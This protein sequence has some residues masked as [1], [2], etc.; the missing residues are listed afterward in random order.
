[1]IDIDQRNT[2][3]IRSTVSAQASGDTWG[4]GEEWGGGATWGSATVSSPT[5][6]SGTEAY[7]H[8]IRYEHSGVDTPVEIL[9]YML[10]LRIRRTE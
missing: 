4:G 8:Q 5:V 6:M 3:P 1:M 10:Q 7:W 2:T 9:S